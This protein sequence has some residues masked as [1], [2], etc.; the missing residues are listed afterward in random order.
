MCVLYMSAMCYQCVM[1]YIMHSTGYE[2]VL[3]CVRY[4]TKRGSSLRLGEGVG[5]V[6]GGQGRE[7]AMVVVVRAGTSFDALPSMLSIVLFMVE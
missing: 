3:V 4:H 6:K 1:H 7:G 2:P 5:C